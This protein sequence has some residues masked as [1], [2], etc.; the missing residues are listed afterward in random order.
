[1]M[2]TLGA[3][4]AVM[5]L[6]VAGGVMIVGCESTSTTDSVIAVTPADVTLSASNGVQVFTASMSSSN[7][8]LVLPLVWM[9][10]DANL[11][12]IKSSVGVSAVYEVKGGTGI[13][14]ITVR[15]QASSEGMAVVRQ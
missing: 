6:A 8:T 7:M 11:G 15:D 13:N 10:S 5:V 12:A 14:T 2:K 9:V 3:L 1:M 4:M